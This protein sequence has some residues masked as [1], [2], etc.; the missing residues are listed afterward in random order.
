MKNSTFLAFALILFSAFMSAYGFLRADLSPER[1][2]QSRL[3]QVS[4]EKED[5]E[6]RAQLAAHQLADYQQ[7]IAT[8]LPDAIKGKTPQES[9][10]L[11]QLASVVGSGGDALKIERASSQF[12]RAKEAFRNKLFEDSNQMFA[13]LIEQYPES[14]HMVESHFLLLEGQFQLGEY[15][16]AIDTTETMIRAFPESELTGFA[17]LRLG[18]IFEIQDRLEDAT[19]IYR[20]VLGNYQEPQ[21]VDQAQTALKAVRL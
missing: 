2:L 16:A 18:R 7:H 17:L 9:Y 5:A 1:R 8:L 11:R 21:L 14:V 15:E 3:A 13:K 6:F 20:A 4:R 10:P 19:E 12:E